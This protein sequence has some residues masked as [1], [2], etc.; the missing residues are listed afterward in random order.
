MLKN[1]LIQK[2]TIIAALSVVLLPLQPLA[3]Q[4]SSEADRLE[5]L[6]QA[7]EQLQQRNAELDKRNAILEKEVSSLKKQ[8]TASPAAPAESPTK[9][10]ATYD[11][12]TYV[13]K[14][15]PVEKT[16]ADKW[17]LS[18]SITEL[19]LF[20]D[21]RFRYDYRGGQT[22]DDS[23]V[24]RP[25]PGVAG[26]DDWQERERERYRLRLGLRGTLVDDWFFGVRLE[27]SQS[28]RSTN[29]TFG[30]D[31]SGSSSA[32][33]NGPFSKVS[34]GINVG[35]AYAGYRGFPDII[36]MGGRMPLDSVLVTT[37]MV[38]DDDINPEGLSEQWKHTFTFGG[39][40]A[41]ESYSKD[42]KT[43]APLAPKSE[44]FLKLD[45]FV[46][47][48]QFIYDGTAFTDPLGP[49]PTHTQPGQSGSQLVPNTNA[50]LLAWQA[51]AKFNF[52]KTFYFQV[53]PTIY[54]YTGNGTSFDTHFQGGD[55]ALTNAASL[56]QNQ[57]G[58]NSL[59]VYDMPWEFGWKIKN[60]PMRILGDFAV[61]FDG[62][63][64]AAAAGH[65]GK[66]DQRYAYRIGAE[67]GQLKKKNDWRLGAFYQHTEQY[68]LDPNLVDSDL[69]DFR[70]NM[71]GPVVQAGY[72]LND[73]VWL[74]VSWAY[75]WRSDDSLGTG[76]TGDLGINPLD[77]Y[78][79]F[80]ADLNI[81]F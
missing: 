14:N 35:Q 3:A 52:P 59:L 1:M 28:V 68:S 65:S 49:R 6:E 77:H 26:R 11:G 32:A 2:L 30:D 58:I 36:L 24:A 48:G 43:I 74:A 40:E 4:T 37:R 15:V 60:L 19:E 31:T 66:G 18:T 50:F 76:G 54:N 29:V 7:V 69:T 75:M 47:L 42:S 12:K 71:Q 79:L 72:K 27:T 55:P 70:L 13:E 46:N 53:A 67:V 73:S 45:L 8:A 21:V 16:S 56:A 20:G 57:N 22:D 44:P 34:D 51:G 80:Q 5:K 39:G 63:D 61:N 41:P 64:R 38:W 62:D 33:N 23:P 17:K 25:A 81:P 9:T 78:Q 10:L